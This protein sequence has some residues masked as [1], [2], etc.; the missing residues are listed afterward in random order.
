ME[1]NEVWRAPLEE[2]LSVKENREV[3]YIPI[4]VK[5]FNIFIIFL[6]LKLLR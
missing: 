5:D 3:S 4:C 1:I 2:N 6:Q